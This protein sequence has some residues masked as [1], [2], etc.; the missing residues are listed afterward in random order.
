[1]ADRH[2]DES[3]SNAKGAGV[4]VDDDPCVC[5]HAD[6]DARVCVD[7]DLHFEVRDTIDVVGR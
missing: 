7:L 5:G 6:P 4:L 2:Q 3:H 1:M